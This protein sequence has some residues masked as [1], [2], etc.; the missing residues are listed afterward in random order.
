MRQSMSWV[1]AFRPFTPYFLPLCRMA[2]LSSPK[3]MTRVGEKGS[4]CWV[5]PPPQPASRA[6]AATVA[7][8]RVRF[9]FW[10]TTRCMTINSGTKLNR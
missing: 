5:L 9:R 1:S 7:R 4:I 8:A 6:A 2:A 10:E 3:A